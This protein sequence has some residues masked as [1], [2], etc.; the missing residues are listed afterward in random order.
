MNRERMP[1]KIYKF[2]EIFLPFD[3]YSSS[4]IKN[5][6]GQTLTHFVVGYHID[7]ENLFSNSYFAVSPKDRLAD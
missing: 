6:C 5:H 2:V 4:C 7:I 3:L 1:A